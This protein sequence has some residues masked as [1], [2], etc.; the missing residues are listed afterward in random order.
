MD[1]WRVYEDVCVM[2]A[3]LWMGSIW[4]LGGH[5]ASSEGATRQQPSGEGE[6]GVGALI[7][8]DQGESGDGDATALG[9]MRSL[10]LGIEGR[11]N[12]VVGL[13]TKGMRK[14]SG[15]SWKGRKEK[16]RDKTKT[17]SETPEPEPA[18]ASS[19]TDAVEDD[20][21]ALTEAHEREAMTTLALLQTFHMNTAWQVARLHDLIDAS[22]PASETDMVLRLL[23]KDV[24]SFDLGPFSSLDAK[25]LEWLAEQY[26]NGRKIVV[27]R[28]WK[29][30]MSFVL[31]WNG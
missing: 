20:R 16:E 8:L 26:G 28:G 17:G 11:P 3:G 23:P 24:L 6:S 31:G 7:D 4:K 30:L 9:T 13:N 12:V 2:C 19:P 15:M 22:P 18:S 10:G 21:D 25:F 1:M 5:A 29:E 27:R 14:S